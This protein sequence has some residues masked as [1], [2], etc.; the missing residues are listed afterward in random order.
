VKILAIGAHPDE[1]EIFMFGMLAAYRQRGD[2]VDFVIAT[3]G[4]T[5]GSPPAKCLSAIRQKEAH[6][7]AALIGADVRLLGFPD[8]ELAAD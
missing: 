1:I 7:S 2:A 5:G 4:A 6:T 3:N 8:G